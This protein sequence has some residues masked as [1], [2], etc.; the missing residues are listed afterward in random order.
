MP[1]SGIVAVLVKKALSVRS[2]NFG[3]AAVIFEYCVEFWSAE[4]RCVYVG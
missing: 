1:L 2:M 3:I 4:F